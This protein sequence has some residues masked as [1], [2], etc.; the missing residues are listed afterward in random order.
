M[1]HLLLALV[2]VVSLSQMSWPDPLPP[3]AWRYD[4]NGDGKI[5]AFDLLYF[6]RFWGMEGIPTPTPCICSTSTP[7][8][9]ETPTATEMETPTQTFTH[10]PT[11]SPTI[12]VITIPLPDLPAGARPLR[13]VHIPAGSF[14]MGSTDTERGRW[15]DHEGPVHQVTIGYDFYMG[16]TEVT[17]AQWYA[18]M[19]HNPSWDYGVGNDYP[20][21]NVSWNNIT[22]SNGFLVRLNALGQGTFRLP[23]EVEWEYACRAGTTT[24]FYF[25][26]S[27]SCAD[28]CQNCAV[29]PLP[30]NRSDFMWY[31]GNNS[32]FSNKPVGGKLPNGFGLYDMHGS[33]WEWCE[34][35]WHTNYVGAPIDGNPWLNL[36]G[37][38]GD[39]VLRGGG[40]SDSAKYCRSAMRGSFNQVVGSGAFGLRVVRLP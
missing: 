34:D 9:S 12:E 31:C 23:L 22:Q 40:V 35:Y 21:N 7:T 10:S 20:V 39:R 28:E 37:S 19:H 16:E 15:S 29:G 33:V 13:L 4:A 8:F 11:P 5:D 36:E 32:P 18:V 3:D 27:L 6:L 25:G 30:G 38:N 26:D 1:R 24:R 17:Q 2:I 14:M